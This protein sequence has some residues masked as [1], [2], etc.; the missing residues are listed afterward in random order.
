MIS[1]LEA[2]QKRLSTIY[3]KVRKH[4]Q[5]I[6]NMMTG[7]RLLLLSLAKVRRYERV[8]SSRIIHSIHFNW[9]CLSTRSRSTCNSVLTTTCSFFMWIK[10]TSCSCHT[11]MTKPLMEIQMLPTWLMSHLMRGRSLY[12]SPGIT[13]SLSVISKR[14]LVESIQ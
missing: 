6:A 4:F 1:K 8:E 5:W 14:Q 2:V 7:I 9:L 10:S 13:W 11:S 3:F 12:R